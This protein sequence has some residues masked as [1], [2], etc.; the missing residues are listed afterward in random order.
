MKGVH[1]IIALLFVA[2]SSVSCNSQ[3]QNKDQA[4]LAAG[5]S[6]PKKDVHENPYLDLRSMALSSTADQIG[7]E[8]PA[9]KGIKVYGFVMDMDLGEGTATLASFLS[10]DA[11]LYLSTGGGLI[12]GREHD[13]VS[14][15][16]EALI[17]KATKYLSKAEKT[18]DTALPS[19]DGVSFYFLTN[20]GIYKGQEEIKN[21]KS[22]SSEWSDLFAEANKVI[23]EIGKIENKK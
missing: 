22:K 5:N 11:S 12:G 8:L 4:S 10:G 6:T 16:T 9:G 2:G 7:V 15:A 18:T 23:G 20:E 1:T 17:A 3:S 19:K 13:N 21:L 14:D